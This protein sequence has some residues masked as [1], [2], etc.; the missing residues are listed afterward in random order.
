MTKSLHLEATR[1][2]T[3]GVITTHLELAVNGGV[4]VQ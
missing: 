1:A 4:V 3:K 2:S